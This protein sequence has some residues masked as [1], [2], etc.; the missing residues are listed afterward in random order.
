MAR[1]VIKVEEG[2]YSKHFTIYEVQAKTYDGKV[3]VYQRYLNEKDAREAENFVDK[4]FRKLYETCWV[5]ETIV[6]C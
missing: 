6:F 1:K 2:K 5:Y 4:Y 3:I